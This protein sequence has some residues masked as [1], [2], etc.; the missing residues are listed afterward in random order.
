MKAQHVPWGI[1]YQAAVSDEYGKPISKKLLT[2]QIT[3]H[4]EQ[5]AG[6]IV[7]QEGHQ[8]MTDNNGIFS[9]VIGKGTNTYAGSAPAFQKINWAEGPYFMEIKT[10]FGS[11]L[12]DMGSF[13]LQSVPYS[14]VADTALNAP[15]PRLAHLVDVNKNGLRI[16][17]A[18][19]WDG[20]Q[21][22][23]GDSLLTDFLFITGD[24]KTGR[25][26]IV[27]SDLNVSDSIYGTTLK[28]K[29]IDADTADINANA[30]VKNNLTVNHN[31]RVNNDVYIDSQLIVKGDVYVIDTT[32]TSSLITDWADITN[33]QLNNNATIG[34]NLDVLNNLSVT[35]TITS[36]S[37]IYALSDIYVKD[38]I[39]SFSLEAV[40]GYLDSLT[41]RVDAVIGNNLNVSHN[42][43][44]SHDFKLSNNAFLRKNLYVSD[45]LTTSVMD[46][47]K[48]DF[49]TLNVNIDAQV[50]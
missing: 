45:S 48:G 34:N 23:P 22:V 26:V 18:L 38:S 5:P 20:Y 25:N 11:G 14:F 32:K 1:N 37:D 46:G 36:D 35:K 7:W 33:M 16:N 19:K 3:I 12:K 2:V 50:G 29:K 17:Q 6:E 39:T 15:I 31:V 41:V 10:D 28:V 30:F 27:L 40:R 42:L 21:W 24:L 49:D 8:V 44:V 13:Q 47:I 9:L 43:T 4:K